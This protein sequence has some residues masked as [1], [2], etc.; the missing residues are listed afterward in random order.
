MSVMKDTKGYEGQGHRFL[1]V[2]FGIFDILVGVLALIL[3]G[4][5]EVRVC[6]TCV[7]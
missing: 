7:W 6:T 3:V 1:G 4:V 2:N 5:L